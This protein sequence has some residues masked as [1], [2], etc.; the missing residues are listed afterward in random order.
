LS[1]LGSRRL[2]PFVAKGKEAARKLVWLCLVLEYPER[3]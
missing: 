3:L 2:Q 1:D